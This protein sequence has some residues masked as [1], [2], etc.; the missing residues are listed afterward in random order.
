MIAAAEELLPPVAKE[1]APVTGVLIANAV[2]LTGDALAAVAIPWFVLETT[3]SAAKAGLSG[4]V[5][6][7]PSLLA[8]IF[9]GTIVDRLG[10]KRSA[11][12]ADIVGGVAVL[13][14]PLLYATVGLA[15]WQLLALVL[16]AG[17]LDV[18]G[19]T[20]RRG[21]LPELAKL[22][23]IRLERV[24]SIL[25][26]NQQLA[27][28]VGPPLAGIAIGLVGAENVLW[29]DAA[30]FA[31]SAG[32]IARLVPGHLFPRRPAETSTSYLHELRAGLRFLWRDRLLR[33]ASLALSLSNAT[34]GAFYSVI[35]I[36]YA[37]D[38]FDSATYLGLL[39][40]ATGLGSLLGSI[41]Y[42]A[43]TYRLPRRWVWAVGFLG[44]PLSHW[45]F[46]FEW[47]F[48]VMLT[49]IFLL[50]LLGG[51]INPLLVT[52]RMERIPL[53]LR[54]RV[55]ATTS[56]IAMGA[57][58]LGIVAGGALVEGLGLTTAVVIVAAIDS[59]IGLAVFLLPLWK[60]LD[61]TRPE[62][63]DRP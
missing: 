36:V 7:A 42:G 29:A 39:F 25:E 53:E 59:A 40:S 33:A 48:P 21:M 38:R 30:S 49:V 6:V 34:G 47:S 8:G 57:Q 46:A 9:G 54:G 37:R 10:P 58:P 26:G 45:L 17:A 5:A 16:L 20:A 32:V 11:V 13:L 44:F 24:N 1:R 60:E 52:V 28:L 23:G 15:F 19:I 14:I 4:G 62:P 22:G 50:S 27:F 35:I 3:G 2:S 61:D 55:F 18:P 63:A 51:G 12:L 41:A 31:L 43:F 56:A